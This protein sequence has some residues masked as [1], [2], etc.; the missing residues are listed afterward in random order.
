MREHK[1]CK[2]SQMLSFL[3]LVS[4]DYDVNNCKDFKRADV[5]A[6]VLQARHDLK[7]IVKQFFSARA[8]KKGLA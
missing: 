5:K 3:Q 1:D 7:E 8:R 4:R 2:R 6:V